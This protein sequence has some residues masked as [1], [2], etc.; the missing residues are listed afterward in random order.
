[1]N[2][3]PLVEIERRE[4]LWPPC[5]KPPLGLKPRIVADTHRALEIIDAFNRYI[6]KGGISSIPAEWVDELSEIIHRHQPKP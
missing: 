2:P 6:R 4:R 1:M 3:D 5:S